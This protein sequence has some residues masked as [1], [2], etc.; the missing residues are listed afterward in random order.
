MP[1]TNIN[2]LTQ[3]TGKVYRVQLSAVQL[4]DTTTIWKNYPQIQIEDPDIFSSLSTSD[5]VR[6]AAAQCPENST[7]GFANIVQKA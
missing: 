1:N 2:L 6:I 5:H 3:N 7:P 4:M